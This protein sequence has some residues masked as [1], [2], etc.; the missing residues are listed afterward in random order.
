MHLENAFTIQGQVRKEFI[1]QQNFGIQ[2]S[3]DILTSAVYQTRG[4]AN[5]P[6]TNSRYK[7]KK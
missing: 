5:Q 1:T 2:Q 4:K 3:L 7:G 6:S